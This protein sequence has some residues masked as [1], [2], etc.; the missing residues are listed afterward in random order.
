MLS[1]LEDYT[2]E[3][4]TDVDGDPSRPPPGRPLVAGDHPQLRR[5]AT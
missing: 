1:D 4:D 5:D 2:Q 3:P